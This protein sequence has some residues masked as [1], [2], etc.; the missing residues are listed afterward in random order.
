MPTK[1]LAYVLLAVAALL[2]FVAVER[3]LANANNVH[4]MNQMGMGP[5]GGRTMT[6]ATPVVSLYCGLF[7]AIAGVAG[8]VLLLKSK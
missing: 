2:T 8:V 1:P 4:A 7:A 5:M 3:Y 6:P